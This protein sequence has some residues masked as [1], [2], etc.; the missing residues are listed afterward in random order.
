MAGRLRVEVVIDGV[1]VVNTF[2]TANVQ[3][4]LYKSSNFNLILL[5]NVQGSQKVHK[6]GGNRIY[7][8]I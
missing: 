3:F 4:F 1:G 2:Q 7:K 8:A 6:I 5:T